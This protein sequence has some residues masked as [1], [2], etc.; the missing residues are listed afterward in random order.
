MS[1]KGHSLDEMIASYERL[2]IME[3]LRRNDWNRRKA[4]VAL[5]IPVRR[6]FKRMAALHFNTSEI[7]RD[8]PGRR[9]IST[10]QEKTG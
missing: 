9:K 6:L 10:S 2:L 7:P 1:A 4:A 8:V 5:Q 3:T